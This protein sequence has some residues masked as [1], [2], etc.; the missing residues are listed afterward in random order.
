LTIDET[1]GSSTGTVALDEP[2]RVARVRT[3]TK[4]HARRA[5][6][7][8]PVPLTAALVALGSAIAVIVVRR[9]RAVK[10]QWRP[11]FLRR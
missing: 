10:N 3:A 7:T 4:R 8:K 6:R 11:G 9:R 1:I 2:G 5:L